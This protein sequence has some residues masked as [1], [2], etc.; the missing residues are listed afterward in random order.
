MKWLILPLSLW[1]TCDGVP[2]SDVCWDSGVWSTGW[3]WVG[4]VWL[5]RVSSHLHAK[6]QILPGSLL[7]FLPVLCCCTH[8]ML[9]LGNLGALLCI[10]S[11]GA[12]CTSAEEWRLWKGLSASLGN[13]VMP[14]WPTRG[15]CY[16]CLFIKQLSIRLQSLGSHLFLQVGTIGLKD[17]T[18]DLPN[19][20]I[21]LN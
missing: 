17:A 2:V 20:Y 9:G 21:F 11:L 19:H 18:I 5:P 8:I 15:W 7:L 3:W 6:L 12:L 1:V 16:F 10:L 13:K 14:C 4:S